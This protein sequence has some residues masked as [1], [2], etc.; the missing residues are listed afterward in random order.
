MD[1]VLEHR[2]Q[3]ELVVT[4]L[5]FL[6]MF[7]GRTIFRFLQNYLIRLG[8]VQIVFDLRAALHNHVT[9]LDLPFFAINKPGFKLT[10]L[11]IFSNKIKISRKSYFQND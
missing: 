10:C 8:A 2:S 11:F 1:S 6:L 3:E 7:S 4:S 5:L 9:S